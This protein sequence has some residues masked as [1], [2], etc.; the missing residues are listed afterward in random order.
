MKREALAHVRFEAHDG[1][2]LEIAT[3]LKSAS[4]GPRAWVQN[5][6]QAAGPPLSFALGLQSQEIG[7]TLLLGA[8]LRAFALRL[9]PACRAPW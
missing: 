7:R 8:L 3:C 4:S 1:L 2:K 9:Q 6:Q 5:A